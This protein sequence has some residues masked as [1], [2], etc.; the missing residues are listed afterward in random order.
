MGSYFDQEEFTLNPIKTLIKTYLYNLDAH[1]VVGN[2][3]YLNRKMTTTE[4]SWLAQFIGANNYTYFDVEIGE[5]FSGHVNVDASWPP[6][7]IYF[8]INPIIEETDRQVVSLLD[9]L[10]NA[11]GFYNVV[12]I[13]GSLAL[14]MFN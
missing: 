2:N 11:G 8:L 7:S 4:D 12:N 10:T 6:F 5:A 3:F 13:A 9:L 1:I 14:M